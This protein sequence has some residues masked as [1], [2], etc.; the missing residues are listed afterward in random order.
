MSTPANLR[1]WIGVIAAV[2]VT[3]LV[4]VIIVRNAP[5]GPPP[6]AT[7]PPGAQVSRPPA[8]PGVEATLSAGRITVTRRLPAPAFALD[9]T[10]TLDLRLP[11]GP[12]E[13]RLRVTFDPRSVRRASL[14]ARIQGGELTIERKG[15]VLARGKTGAES[16]VIMSAPV[17]L[18]PR[19][20]TVT[21]NFRATGDGPT[22]L[23][24]RWRPQ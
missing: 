15:K 8:Q 21:Y 19:L 23:R 13:A 16:T 10:E 4:M 7:R 11:P 12:F 24:A 17:F 20:V 6:P 14:G 5:L 18:P 9:Q 3:I 22:L 1:S 2:S